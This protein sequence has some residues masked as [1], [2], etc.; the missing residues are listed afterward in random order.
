MVFD[1]FT[2]VYV[3]MVYM[4]KKDLPKG[5]HSLSQEEI[6]QVKLSSAYQG[7]AKLPG[8]DS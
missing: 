1:H 2:P 7:Q 5:F 4:W 8:E 6:M 3:V